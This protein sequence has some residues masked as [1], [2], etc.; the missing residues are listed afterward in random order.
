MSELRLELFDDG[1]ALRLARADGTAAG[2][3][4]LASGDID[5]V[6]DRAGAEYASPAPNLPRLG[7]GLFEWI[8]GPGERWL[9]GCLAERHDHLTLRIDVAGR[10]R[11]LP[12]ELLAADHGLLCADV[13]RPFSPVR[14]VHGRTAPWSRQNRPLRVLFMAASPIDVE[15]VLRYEDE[16]QRILTA[17]GHGGVELVV[18]ESGSLAGLRERLREHDGGWY[19]VLH[20]TGHAFVHPQRGPALVM[21]ADTGERHD[22]GAAE[23]TRAIEGR[24]PRIVFVSGCSTGASPRAGLEPSFAESLVE[25]GARCVLGWAHPV[26]D[27]SATVLAASLYEQLGV[28]ERVDVAVARARGALL[29]GGS[30]YWHLLRAY[31]DASPLD[32]LVTARGEK[33][34]ER[35]RSR[36]AELDF[37][38]PTDPSKTRVCPASRFIGRR[39]L[40]QRGLRMLREL[41]P[42]A[43]EH[44]EGIVLHGMGGLGKS[45]LAARLCARMAGHRRL[46]WVGELDEREVMRVISERFGGASAQLMNE[47]GLALRHRLA[48]MLDAA[49]DPL[50]FVL[51]DFERSLE[52]GAA[53][54]PRLAED[55]LAVM[56]PAAAD[57]LSAMLWAIRETESESRVIVTCRYRF[58]APAGAARLGEI[59]LVGLA[60]ADLEKKV[61][62]LDGIGSRSTPEA[63]RA[64]ALELA[65]GNPRL[66]EWC[67]RALATP[68]LD[69]DG[70]LLALQDAA[71]QFR[72]DII[73]RALIEQLPAT[74]QELLR[75]LAVCRLP[76]DEPTVA[77]IAWEATTW[78]RTCAA[79]SPP[80]CS[81]PGPSTRA[82]RRATSSPPS[83]P[84]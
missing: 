23:L 6:V 35:L 5:A 16:E 60:G 38:D 21:E 83:W 49:P 36:P 15:P 26:G 75:W 30:P 19:D 7:R 29:D 81:R 76:V 66:M 47:P 79:P 84:S 72:E 51:D 78:P 8:D 1:R 25:S 2:R 40:L 3:R 17:A 74:C 12:W 39:R 59:G 61:G 10:L 44:C 28:G 50:L 33:G 34:R 45:S 73:V 13:A 52:R 9:G 71:E 63:Q 46:V 65:G 69:A 58:V 70:M 53:G 68:G 4:D 64:R 43:R 42:T 82:K 56:R 18:E 14:Q 77:A 55:G 62:Q 20:L 80:G 54:A 57:A 11:H 27:D 67:D 32:A 37:L 24:W 22:V 31:A 48:G 41:D